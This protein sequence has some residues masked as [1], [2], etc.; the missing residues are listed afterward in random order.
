MS[1]NSVLKNSLEVKTAIAQLKKMGLFPHHGSEK[2]WDTFKMIEIIGKA[3]PDA[4]VLDV[5]CNGSPIL[6]ML[7]KLGFRNLYGCDFVLRPRY[8]AT[9]MKIVC[10]FYKKE[11]LSIIQMYNDD[12]IKLSIQN[13]EKTNYSNNMFDFITSLSVIE[14]GVDIDEYFREM[15]RILKSGGYL[16]TSTDYWHEKITNARSVISNS[17][18]DRV[19]CRDEIEE[20]IKVGESYGLKLIEPMDYTHGD[21]VVKWK[22]TGLDYTFIFFGMKKK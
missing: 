20:I 7:R 13:L 2:S 17:E 8:N 22:K 15:T 19:F 14:H 9:F 21:K 3:N 11:Y 16:L 5:G 1:Y 18:P 12:L 4:Y 6:P 10:R